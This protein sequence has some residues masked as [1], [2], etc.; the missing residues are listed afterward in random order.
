MNALIVTPDRDQ[1]PGDWSGAFAVEAQRLRREIYPGAARLS[2]NLDG[3]PRAQRVQLL[4]ALAKAEQLQLLAI[5]C[6]GW[7][8]GLQIGWSQQDLPQLADALAAAAAP[9]LVVVLYACSTAKDAP[10]SPGTA[11]DG[12]FA[13]VLRDA[14]AQKLPA[15]RGWVDAHDRAGHCCRNPY[16]RRMVAGACVGGDW[17]IAPDS[18]L[19]PRWDEALH[20]PVSTLR[21]RYPFMLREEIVEELGR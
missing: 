21:L 6:H 16:V 4:D 14:L 7:R 11:G 20:D 19:W 2:V 12:G 13:D 8:T 17:L 15:W 1:T 9:D 3:S 18:G 10:D 5:L